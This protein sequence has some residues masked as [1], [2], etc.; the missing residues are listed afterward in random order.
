MPVSTPSFFLATCIALAS[1]ATVADDRSLEDL[2]T[3]SLEELMNLDVQVGARTG[4]KRLHNHKLP[5]D[6]VTADD[7]RR[8]GYGELP[9][10]LNHLVS[11]FTYEF[12]TIDDLT[13]H[14]RPFSLNGLKGDQVL[15]LIN[16]KRV[17]QGAVIDVND[18]QNLGS[19]SVDLNLIPLEAIERIEILRDDAS[20]QYGSDAIAGVINIVLKSKTVNEAVVTTG[21]RQAG[22]GELFSGSY[23][24]GSETLFVSLEYKH[25]SHSNTSG[26]DRRDYYFNG[27]A[28]NGDYR[29]T[30][31]YGD[32]DAQ[33]LSLTFNGQNFFDNN[34]LYA[35]GKLVYKESEAAGFFRRPLDN[36]T[37]RAVYPDGF[38]PKIAPK[39]QD[40]FTT[41]GYREQS[42][43]YSYDISNTI[44]YN[45]MDIYVEDSLNTSLGLNTPTD[46]NSGKLSFWQNTLNADA[47]RLLAWPADNP[48]NLAYGAEYR[49]EEA[50][51]GAGEWAS[52]VDGLTPI[53][54]GPNSGGDTV[55]GAQ[56]YPGF[57]P[58]N[59]NQ[60]SRN[61][62]AIY[63]EANHQ[64]TQKL[65]TSI[66]LRNEH[67]SD[68]GN[69][70]NGK[71]SMNYML[72]DSFNIR[73]SVS[74]G[75]RAPSLQQMSYYRTATSYKVETNGS[76][77]AQE[78]GTFPVSNEVA[79]LLGA[80]DLNPEES[81]RTN[82]GFT[83]QTTNALQM[84]LDFF[85]INIDDRIILSGDI[86]NTTMIP[87]AAQDYMRTNNIS[88]AR[89]FLNGVDTRSLGF[90]ASVKYRAYVGQHALDFHAQW[91]HQQTNIKSLHIP[92]QL[93]PIA[94]QVFDRSEQERLQHYL[95]QEKGLVA[96][97]YTH[98]NWTLTTRA[99]YFGKVLYVSDPSNP[100]HDQWFGAKTTFDMDIA[101]QL[102][103][104]S[105][106]ALGSHNMFNTRPDTRNPSPPFNGAGNI[107]QYRGISPFDY[108]G[109]YYY[110]RAQM[111]F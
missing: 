70:L 66:S 16:G 101:Y 91:H 73:T 60:S 27:D 55:G 90:D 62:V 50:R 99:N 72:A 15:V 4:D 26:L 109:A 80:Q 63:T 98:K 43:S 11:S 74:T 59:A 35:Q 57:S 78:N 20:A 46:F 81:Q 54:D 96:A 92:S 6:I 84:N 83:W 69:T 85:Q 107:F 10:V 51:I 87:E 68:F 97:T 45:K 7:L 3:L 30:H 100:A 58:A 25:K 14:V 22:D 44:G 93:A 106:L 105:S 61:I 108:T 77:T 79:R 76:V 12:A 48:L 23:N 41:L 94:N 102:S 39:Q 64:I 32:P 82:I 18:S 17:H 49:H 47:T 67:Y 2:L 71:L 42:D 33:S 9:K 103:T 53:I 56:L 28:R 38:L 89:Y 88:F 65:E 8:S 29:V 111:G 31:I 13:D 19:S 52:W 104:H 110:L 34:H 37:I 36:R 5:V 21:Q 75:Y 40:L 86:N 1:T 24:Y 95:P